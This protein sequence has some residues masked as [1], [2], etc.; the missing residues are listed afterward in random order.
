MIPDSFCE[1]L[2]QVFDHFPEYDTKLHLEYF[3]EK[4]GREDIFKTSGKESLYQDNNVRVL[5]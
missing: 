2:K 3:N 1:E 5:E 4:L